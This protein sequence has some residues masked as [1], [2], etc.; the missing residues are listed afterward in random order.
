MYT[1]HI[2]RRS[3][4]VVHEQIVTKIAYLNRVEDMAKR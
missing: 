3:D 1:Y 2:T 4:F